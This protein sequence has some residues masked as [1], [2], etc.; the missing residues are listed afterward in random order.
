MSKT[1]I[2]VIA[3]AIVTIVLYSCIPREKE[4]KSNRP[5]PETKPITLVPNDK[6]VH[7]SNVSKANIAKV[8]MQFCDLYNKESFRALPRLIIISE[9]E[10]AITFPFDV[11]F[12]TFC[13]FVNYLHY[14]FDVK[15]EPRIRA[16]TSTKESDEWIE[17]PVKGQRVMLFIPKDDDEYDNVYLTT[18]SHFG[19]IVGFAIGHHFRPLSHPRELYDAPIFAIN[20][21]IEKEFID[22][23]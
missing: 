13:I 6:L 12:V 3:I 2:L 7:V 5:S 9:K 8:L 20:E 10:Y 21:L 22:F 14:P 23:N 15:Y 16:W 17:R 18:E 11:D 1:L 4:K 19:V